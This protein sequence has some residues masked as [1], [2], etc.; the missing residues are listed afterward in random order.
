MI[1]AD[2]F[3][4]VHPGKI[5]EKPDSFLGLGKEYGDNGEIT[6]SQRNL[7]KDMMTEGNV[8][9]CAPA[10]TPITTPINKE[11]RPEDDSEAAKKVL[12]DIY[13]Y[14]RVVGQAIWLRQSRPELIYMYASSQW[15]RVSSNPGLPH[16]AAIKRGVRYLAGTRNLGTTYG[17]YKYKKMIHT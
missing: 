16:H 14:M 1:L 12:N 7:I 8:I 9:K 6:I 10:H 15:A 3:M 13:P 2:G 4:K 17:R 5:D 11:E